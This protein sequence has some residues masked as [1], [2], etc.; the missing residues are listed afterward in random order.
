MDH[1]KIH[2]DL[3]NW[4]MESE[5]CPHCP[6]VRLQSIASTIEHYI[7]RHLDEVQPML[8]AIIQAGPWGNTSLT[9]KVSALKKYL[10]IEDK[11]KC[12]FL[13]CMEEYM[14]KKQ[15]INHI[16]AKHACTVCNWT[17]DNQASLISHI[18]SHNTSKDT[19]FSCNICGKKVTSPKELQEHTNNHN[20]FSC[21][22][23]FY[24]VT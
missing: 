22:K 7:Y 10:G 16:K 5:M 23:M 20:K 17:A 13:E 8:T 18:A 21:N 24:H 6:D 11:F 4:T 1:L 3:W 14:S 15:L 19:T 2:H 12:H 9:K